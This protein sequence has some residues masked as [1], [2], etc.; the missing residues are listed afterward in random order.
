MD[1]LF[2]FYFGGKVKG[3]G[4]GEGV[5]GRVKEVRGKRERIGKAAARQERRAVR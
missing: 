4:K 2:T 1:D 3:G 5:R